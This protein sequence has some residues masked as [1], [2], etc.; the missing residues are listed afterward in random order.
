MSAARLDAELVR[1][2][3]ARSRRRAAELIVEGRVTVGGARAAKPA[4]QVGEQVEVSVDPGGP[5][6]VSR[7]GAKLA[8]ALDEIAG[9]TG[10]APTAAGK[11]CLDAGAST[12]GFT[13]VLLE[14][15]ATGVLAVDVGHGQLVPALVRDPRVDSREGVNVRD[16]TPAD[17]PWQPDLVVGDLSFI[18][19]T[20]VV[21]VLAGLLAP[22]A[23]LVLLVKPQ[24]EVGRGR[25]GPGGVV[26]SPQRRE[27]AVLAVATALEQ[28]R[29]AVNA[30]VPSR[31]PGPAGNR[32]YFLWAVS[33]SRR[34]LDL[35]SALP[36]AVHAAV[37]QD[38]A[39]LVRPPLRGVP[40]RLA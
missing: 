1:R 9:L 3:L 11:R 31:V 8:G 30:V 26:T 22:G 33:G 20:L 12:G 23:D 4:Q 37:H 5:E 32:E 16:L 27:Q 25:L 39:V 40:R 14:R 38:S 28:E 17:L 18:S 21:P 6:Y 24:Y 10:S 36:Q 7:A 29:A 2:G 34:T 13:Q 19:L 15:G 35:A